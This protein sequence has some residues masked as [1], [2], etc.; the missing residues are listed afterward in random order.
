MV[1][2]IYTYLSADR[3][4]HCSVHISQN[5]EEI[6]K[7]C[8]FSGYDFDE[9]NLFVDE[10]DFSIKDKSLTMGRDIFHYATFPEP[11]CKLHHCQC[12]SPATA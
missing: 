8:M 4:G 12:C 9:K 10:I 2:K 5:L 11:E 3:Y 7:N 6:K 1:I